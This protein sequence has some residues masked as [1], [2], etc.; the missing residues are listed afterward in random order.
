M[1]EFD[2]DSMIKEDEIITYQV[3]LGNRVLAEK[4]SKQ[5]A[6]HFITT[7]GTEQQ[8]EAVVVPVTGGKQVLFG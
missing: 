4:P 8:K 3:K 7:L 2:M 6:E 1:L 5:L